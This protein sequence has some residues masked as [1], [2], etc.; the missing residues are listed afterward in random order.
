MRPGRIGRQLRRPSLELSEISPGWYHIATRRLVLANASGR[1]G[2]VPQGSHQARPPFSS[3]RAKRNAG[4]AVDSSPVARRWWVAAAALLAVAGN[5]RQ[6]APITFPCDKTTLPER[7]HVLRVYVRAED[8]A[9]R[10]A[11][12]NSWHLDDRS[13]RQ[14]T[15]DDA[16][17]KAGIVQTSKR[18]RSGNTDVAH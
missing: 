4:V 14:A 2:K 9:G 13:R 8:A 3:V 5:R 17:A 6:Y 18:K 1:L 12:A 10:Y 15:T 16:C 11:L 7:R